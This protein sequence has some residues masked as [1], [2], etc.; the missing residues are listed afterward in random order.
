[1]GETLVAD[2]RNLNH[3]AV[4]WNHI[5][6]RCSVPPAS[7]GRVVF[8]AIRFPGRARFLRA[9]TPIRYSAG[10]PETPTEANRHG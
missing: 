5:R 7:L 9:R 8:L 2:G 1:M 3:T 4:C 10:T 6:G